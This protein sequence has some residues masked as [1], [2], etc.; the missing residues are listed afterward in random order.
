MRRD[1]GSQAYL[2][3]GA[4][5]AWLAAAEGKG[6]G[7]KGNSKG[8]VRGK[9][10]YS[11]TPSPLPFPCSPVPLLLSLELPVV[12][13]NDARA[14]AAAVIRIVIVVH[15]QVQPAIDGNRQGRLWANVKI[16]RRLTATGNDV[17]DQSTD[18]CRR[19]RISARA[20]N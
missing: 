9:G 10:N 17:T 5:Y 14:E 1:L 3:T 16:L 8:K 4:K 18:T 7:V 20:E 6:E 15:H 11:F 2:W 13:I 19:N 12:G